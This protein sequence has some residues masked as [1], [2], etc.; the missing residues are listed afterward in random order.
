MTSLG[1]EE[2]GL[3][4]AELARR[5]HCS[6]DYVIATA[7]GKPEHD[8]SNP[9][10]SRLGARVSRAVDGGSGRRRTGASATCAQVVYESIASSITRPGRHQLRSLLLSGIVAGDHR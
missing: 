3:T 10:R 5:I 8:A 4:R 2:Q 6:R 1:I 9:R 7:G